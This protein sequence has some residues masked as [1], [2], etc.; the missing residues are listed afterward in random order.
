MLLL[1][2]RPGSCI[3]PGG[4]LY[5]EHKLAQA[6]SRLGSYERDPREVAG[7]RALAEKAAE[8]D[9][10]IA[11]ARDILK[12]ADAKKKK[13]K[14]DKKHKKDKKDKKSKRD[15]KEKKG[16]M[17]A[18]WQTLS[19]LIPQPDPV[20]L[21][22]STGL[23][24]RTRILAE[25]SAPDA[26]A[27]NAVVPDRL[28][29]APPPN[30]PPPL[31][32]A[33]RPP[34]AAHL[35][36]PRP[37]AHPL[38]RAL[39]QPPVRPAPVANASKRARSDAE[40]APA[41]SGKQGRLTLFQEAEREAA[42]GPLEKDWEPRQF[43]V[44]KASEAALHRRN[45]LETLCRAKLRA[46]ALGAKLPADLLE[47]W[48]RFAQWYESLECRNRGAGI[49]FAWYRYILRPLDARLQADPKSFVAWVR[50]RMDEMPR[51]EKLVM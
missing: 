27:D 7:R 23:A 12:K 47:R 29:P 11:A 41:I 16:N 34:S 45:R 17:A 24:R 48:P 50:K 13:D 44:G 9:A 51:R 3:D 39:A 26:P 21:A 6:N 49:G 4:L 31:V 35:P 8:R 2:R 15:K 14:K 10:E 5:L 40:A 33:P 42:N 28:P 25:P 36:A 46:E 20:A 18:K 43:D 22:L 19:H 1:A 32:Q 38:P 30:S 37:S